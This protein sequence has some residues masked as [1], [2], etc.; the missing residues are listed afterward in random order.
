[1]PRLHPRA[2]TVTAIVFAAAATRLLP[3]LPNVTPVAALALFGGVYLADRRLAVLIP[4]LAM[5]LSDLVLGFH[6]G[7]FA[8]YVAMVVIAGLGML[9]R[10]R[11]SPLR[12]GGMAV[13]GSVL[14]FLL[15]N[16][17]GV[18]GHLY[19]LTLQ[20]VMESYTAALPFFRYTLLGDLAYTA[21]LFGGFA[22]LKTRIPALSAQ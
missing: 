15:T 18:S 2:V 8:V 12:V 1:M 10:A 21:L 22:L 17:P 13:A 11:V 5:F 7:M 20:G 19:P 16:I 4:L 3:H 14:F 6:R 9:I